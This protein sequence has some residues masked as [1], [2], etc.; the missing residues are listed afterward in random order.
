MLRLLSHCSLAQMPAAYRA[1]SDFY[2]QPNN[3][4][5]L[6]GLASLNLTTL[7]VTKHWQSKLSLFT[8]TSLLSAGHTVSQPQCTGVLA[9]LHSAAV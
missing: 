8:A 5:E 3:R 6:H 9:L 7:E 4:A 1:C 2:T